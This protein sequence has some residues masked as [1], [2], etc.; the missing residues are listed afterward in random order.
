MSVLKKMTLFCNACS[1]DRPHQRTP[2]H[3][4]Q[5]TVCYQLHSPRPWTPQEQVAANVAARGY[6]D[7]WTDEQFIGRQVAKLFEEGG[8]LV[9]LI[10]T[11]RALEPRWVAY[12]RAAGRL[13]RIAFDENDW[14]HVTI[15]KEKA[16]AELAD[17]A[18]VVLTMADALGF[19]VCRAAVEKSAADVERGKR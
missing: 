10:E 13:C 9:K 1:K 12:A 6:R 14:R 8:E 19:D 16:K 5:C 3:R 2:E 15:D 11:G 17:I 18:V 4:Y 7:G